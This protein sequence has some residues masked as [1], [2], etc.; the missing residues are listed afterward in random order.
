MV[1][2]CAVCGHDKNM[3][4]TNADRIRSMTDEELALFLTERYAKESVLRV[5]EQGYEPTATQIKALHEGLYL[6]WIRWL[7]QPAEVE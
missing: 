5:R 4:M 2:K 6:T 7:Q 1:F 3:P